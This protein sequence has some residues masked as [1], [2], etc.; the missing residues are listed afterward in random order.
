MSKSTT[1]FDHFSKA[2]ESGSKEDVDKALSEATLQSKLAMSLFTNL[3][4]AY[5]ELAS[6]Y[7]KSVSEM[8]SVYSCD[9]SKNKSRARTAKLMGLGEKFAFTYKGDRPEGMLSKLAVERSIDIIKELK[10]AACHESHESF[11][12]M[13]EIGRLMIRIINLGDLRLKNLSEWR[14]VIVDY[15]LMWN[16]AEDSELSSKIGNAFPYIDLMQES[17][18][19][20][21]SRLNARKEERLNTLHKKYPDGKE[22]DEI[23]KK[24]QSQIL[25]QEAVYLTRYQEGLREI[26][27]MLLD[28]DCWHYA[29][30]RLVG[31]KLKRLLR[32]T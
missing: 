9:D 8:P 14:S 29:V 18:S 19:Y 23:W 16:G 22:L 4:L 27:L 11:E 2:F 26:E 24:D 5:P 15:V 10:Q 28:R 31:E 6:D 20:A 21:E 13:G 7:C 30:S 25:P 3:S 17:R 1:L 32:N 12:Y